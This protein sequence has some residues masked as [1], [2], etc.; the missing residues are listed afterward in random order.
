[1]STNQPV[2]VVLVNDTSLENTHF[3]CQLVG[4]TIREQLCR[5][6][7]E[8]IAAFPLNF[9]PA[10]ARPYFRQ[11]DLVLINGEGSIHHGKNLHLL[12]LADEYPSALINCIYQENGFQPSLK[13]FLYISARESLSAE[14]IRKQGIACDIT[15]DLLF[16]SSMLRATPR[17]RQNQELGITDNVVNPASGFSPKA[18]LAY[19]ILS[20]MVRCKRIVAGRFHAAVAACVMGIPFS[21]WDSN[22]W[23]TRGLM[24]DIGIEHLHFETQQGA[25]ANVPD[26]LDPRIP[27]YTLKARGRI[28]KTFEQLLATVRFRLHQPL[29]KTA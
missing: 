12:H 28:E 24:Q 20:N 14:E 3:G 4:Q 22:T 29:H 27:E 16:G 10:F 5:A 8:L 23:K 26:E 18:P 2:K 7:A 6:N 11:A 21:T 25:I 13:N 17:T 9:K 19:D 15:P 1:M